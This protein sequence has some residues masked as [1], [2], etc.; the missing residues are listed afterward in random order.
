MNFQKCVWSVGL[1]FLVSFFSAFAQKEASKEV[2][3]KVFKQVLADVE[4]RECI[5]KEEGGVRTAEVGPL[6]V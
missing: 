2:K 3:S 1:V 5:E 4:L 6:H